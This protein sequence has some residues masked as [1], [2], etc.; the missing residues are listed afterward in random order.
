MLCLY[1]LVKTKSKNCKVSLK[2]NECYHFKNKN[3]KHTVEVNTSMSGCL[4]NKQ[5]HKVIMRLFE[6]VH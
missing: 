3:G 5:T 4:L 2:S 1:L 6:K